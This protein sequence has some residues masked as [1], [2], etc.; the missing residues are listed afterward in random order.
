M[1][2]K[3]LHVIVRTMYAELMVECAR[4]F[5]VLSCTRRKRTDGGLLR[6]VDRYDGPTFRVLRRYLAAEPSSP[7]VIF[8][9]SSEHGL[10]DSEHQIAYYDRAMTLERADQLRDSAVHHL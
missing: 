9:L 10:I 6:A 4:R 1:E 2:I 5:L 7:P 3:A 8:I